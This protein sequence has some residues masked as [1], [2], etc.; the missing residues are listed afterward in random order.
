M[1]TAARRAAAS[2]RVADVTTATRSSLSA[3]SAMAAPA[4]ARSPS[5]SS[6]CPALDA[7]RLGDRVEIRPQ[8]THDL[9]GS[10]AVHCGPKRSLLDA[11]P[12]RPVEPHPLRRLARLDEHAV[13]VEE[14]GRDPAHYSV[15]ARAPASSRTRLAIRY[16]EPVATTA[17]PGPA[18]PRARV[19]AAWGEGTVSTGGPPSFSARVTSVAGDSARGLAGRVNT[20]RSSSGS[21]VSSMPAAS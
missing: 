10:H 1:P 18:S 14:D 9:D 15:D 17:P 2:R 7:L 16:I 3:P 6:A 19:S 11:V 4:M 12:R 13:E 5:T 20:T 21:S 8:R